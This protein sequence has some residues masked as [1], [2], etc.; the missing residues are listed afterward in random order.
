VH[1]DIRA[2][3]SKEVS[4]DVAESIRIIYGG[5]VTGA[6]SGELSEFIRLILVLL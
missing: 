1:H 2:Y 4:Q 6:N 5:S 3:L